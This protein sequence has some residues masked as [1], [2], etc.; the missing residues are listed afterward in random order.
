[1]GDDRRRIHCRVSGRVQGVWFRASTQREAQALGISG[2]VRN[3]LGGG[4]ELSAQG[5]REAVGR[6]EQWLRRGPPR[7]HV[8]RVDVSDEALAPQGLGFDILF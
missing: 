8:E 2:W 5:S 6:L 3:L 4:V 1:M 7:A